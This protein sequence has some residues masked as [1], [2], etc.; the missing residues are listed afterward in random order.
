MCV[1]VYICVCVYM[2]VYICVCVCIYM[3]VYVCIHIHV[4]IFGI[5]FYTFWLLQMCR[6]PKRELD[7]VSVKRSACSFVKYY[8]NAIHAFMCLLL[9][10]SLL[11]GLFWVLVALCLVLLL[12]ATTSASLYNPQ[13]KTP[14]GTLTIRESGKCTQYDTSILQRENS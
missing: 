7:L 14:T 8:W 3:C 9:S 1:S 13:K 2:C 11:E 4:E 12:V 6:E 5:G 10:K